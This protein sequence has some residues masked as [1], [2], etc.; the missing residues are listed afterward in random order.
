MENLPARESLSQRIAVDDLA[1]IIR[2]ELYAWSNT[3]S[4][5]I[6]REEVG[7]IAVCI[8]RRVLEGR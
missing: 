4:L 8:A 5:T 1:A 6:P 3:L 2:E 7:I